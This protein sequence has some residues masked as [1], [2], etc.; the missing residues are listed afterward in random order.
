MVLSVVASGITNGGFSPND[1]GPLYVIN[2]VMFPPEEK[3]PQHLS[4]ISGPYGHEDCLQE[5]DLG[6]RNVLEAYDKD[7]DIRL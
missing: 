4:T 7:Q 3:Q 5:I 2:P 1:S 6:N